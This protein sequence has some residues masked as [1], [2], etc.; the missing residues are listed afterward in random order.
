LD[1]HLLG[2]DLLVSAFLVLNPVVSGL[3]VLYN[4]TKM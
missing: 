4:E 1:G 2:L 3:A